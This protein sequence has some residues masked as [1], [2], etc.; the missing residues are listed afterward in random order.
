M[1]EVVNATVSGGWATPANNG[2]SL[3]TWAD[4][5]GVAN[6][7][8]RLE[9]DSAAG[10]YD[11]AP[12]QLS[13]IQIGEYLDMPH[14][15]D[16]SVSK[17]IVYDGVKL[18]NSVGGQT[19]ANASHIRPPDWIQ[20][21]WETGGSATINK[22]G[23]SG[24]IKL[25]MKFSYLNDTDVFPNEFYDRQDIV[26]GNDITSNLIFRT[27]GGMFPFLFQFDN[28]TATQKDSF[29]WCRLAEEPSFSQVANNVWDTSIKLIE[30]Y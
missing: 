17:S 20:E 1:T 11:T 18:Q 19:Y 4:A 7:Y 23:R 14:S 15:P 5:T 22:Y 21:P 13:T 27:N 24:R 9:I 8:I 16:L 29:M 30:E 28:G 2:W 10:N 12:M 25:D 26:T 3:V 6:Q